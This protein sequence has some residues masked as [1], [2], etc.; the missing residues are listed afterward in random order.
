MVIISPKLTLSF[1][2]SIALMLGTKTSVKGI[3]P[4]LFGD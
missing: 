3:Y 1:V 2:K 4:F